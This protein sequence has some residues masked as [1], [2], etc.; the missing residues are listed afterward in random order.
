MTALKPTAADALAGAARQLSYA[1]AES[2]TVADAFQMLYA[3]ADSRRQ[4]ALRQLESALRSPE[5]D[6]TTAKSLRLSSFPTLAWLLRQ[7][8]DPDRSAAPLFAEFQRH[9]SFSATTII[10]VWSGFAGSIAYL[11]AV[12]GLL[13]AVLSMY[14]LFILPQFKGFYA[15]FGEGLPALT[16]LV[17]VRGAP[18]SALMILLAAVLLAYLFWFAFYVRRQLRRYAP[19]SMRYQR[20][21]LLGPV[22]IAYNQY[23]WLSYAEVLRAARM[24]VDQALIVSGMRLPLPSVGQWNAPGDGS[25]TRGV[26]D[27]SG[28]IGDLSIAARLGK[29]EDEV[30]FQQ[31]ATVDAFLTELARCRRRTRIGLSILIYLLVATF[32]SAMYLPIFSVGSAI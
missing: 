7:T 32:V 30:R 29:L 3:V 4:S 19:M 24:P 26:L 25:T 1:L 17:L 27:A 9:Q 20:L 15:G 12:L 18:L 5:S 6:E 16:S 8:S 10:T 22:A 14:G 13:I 28:L 31:D 21:P 2:A 11:G 23:L